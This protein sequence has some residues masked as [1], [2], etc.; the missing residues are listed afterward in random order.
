MY[1]KR[2]I[3]PELLAVVFML[4]LCTGLFVAGIMIGA[5]AENEAQAEF[6]SSLKPPM[7]GCII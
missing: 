6:V 5:Q 3:V 4:L 1:K 7:P 2:S